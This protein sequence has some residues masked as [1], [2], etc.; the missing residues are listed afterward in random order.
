MLAQRLLP[1][2]DTKGLILASEVCIATPAVRKRS[3]DGE[4][5]LLFSDMQMGRKHQMQTLD[6]SLLDLYQRGEISYDVALSNAR[7]PESIRQRSAVPRVVALTSHAKRPS[8]G[9]LWSRG[10][11]SRDVAILS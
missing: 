3:R 11:A 4:P 9:G 6:A 8:L 5:H 7:E 2:A 10:T 1:R